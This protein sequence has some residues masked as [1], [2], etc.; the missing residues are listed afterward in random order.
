MS[1]KSLLRHK[2]SVSSL[3]DFSS[4]G[5]ATVLDDAELHTK[6]VKRV[7]V[8]SGKI[9]FD[10]LIARKEN[11]IDD[12]AIIR[13]EQLYPFPKEEMLDSLNRYPNADELIWVQEEPRNQGA[14]S[15]LRSSRFL[16]GCLDGDKPLTCIARPPSSSPAVGY[17]AL[18]LE[19]QNQIIKDALRLGD[20]VV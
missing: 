19:Q 3:A 7:L 5:F 15:T 10:L 16:A 17:A 12:C 20:R 8:C 4:G 1:P 2:L 11:R 13:L 18:H 14:W 6:S 9:Y